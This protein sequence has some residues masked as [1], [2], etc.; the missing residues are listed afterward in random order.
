MVGAIGEVVRGEP[1][2][3][4]GAVSLKGKAFLKTGAVSLKGKAFPVKRARCPSKGK[5]SL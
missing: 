1:P 3:K 5:P 4:T 2:C